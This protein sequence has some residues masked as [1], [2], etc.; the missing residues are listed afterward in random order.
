MGATLN[1]AFLELGEGLLSFFA[2]SLRIHA[3]LRETLVEGTQ[4][5]N[6]DGLLQCANYGQNPS[7]PGLVFVDGA[8]CRKGRTIRNALR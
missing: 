1:A 3:K 8:D 7:V 2:V 5:V 6:G 4:I